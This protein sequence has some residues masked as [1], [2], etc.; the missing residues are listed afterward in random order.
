MLPSPGMGSGLVAVDWGSTRFRAYRI[1]AGAVVDRLASARGIAGTPPEALAGVLV[2]ALAPWRPWIEDTRVPVA[3]IGMIGSNRGLRD[4]GYTRL[5]VT[6]DE[7]ASADVEVEI[8]SALA[9]RVAIRRGLALEDR[10]ADAFDVMRG[11]DVQLLGAE[12]LRPAGLYV[13]P[14]TH[15]KWIPVERRAGHV[16]VRTFTTVM[17]GEL[18]A[19]LVDESLVCRGIPDARL[20]SDEAFARGVES[21]TREGE[22]FIEMFRTRARWLL[23]DLAPEAAPSYLSGLLIGHEIVTMTKRHATDGRVIVVGAARLAALYANAMARLGIAAEVVDDEAALVG[24]FARMSD[25][26]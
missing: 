25:G 7:L 22:L 17:T 10:Q 11:E 8:A 4:A 16:S 21:A 13:L 14:G 23:G 15:S 5:P 24:G 3:M 6:L 12:R 9:T 18:Y 1:E 26:R 2:E 20:W 19:W